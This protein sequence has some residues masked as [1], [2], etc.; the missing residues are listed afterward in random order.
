MPVAAYCFRHPLRPLS[1]N[2]QTDGKSA[3]EICGG[4]RLHLVARTTAQAKRTDSAGF[5]V[6]RRRCRE[7]SR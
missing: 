7:E 4:A 6:E 1:G 5:P 2:A 3:Q